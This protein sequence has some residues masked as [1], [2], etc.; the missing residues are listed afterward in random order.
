MEDGGGD[1]KCIWELSRHHICSA[2][3]GL[4]PRPNR[5]DAERLAL[6]GIWIDENPNGIGINWTSSLEV[7]FERSRGVGSGR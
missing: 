1:V 3:A 2:G 4:L 5:V 7:A 6:L